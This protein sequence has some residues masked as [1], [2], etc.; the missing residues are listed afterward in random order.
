MGHRPSCVPVVSMN[1]RIPTTTHP[2]HFCL[3]SRDACTAQLET[4]SRISSISALL[5]ASPHRQGRRKWS[6]P[7]TVRPR[8]QHIVEEQSTTQNTR[9]PSPP[10]RP[11]PSSRTPDA[12]LVE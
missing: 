6:P 7:P 1:F 8:I 9:P 10:R 5:T 11:C 4:A 3:T 12:L 2:P